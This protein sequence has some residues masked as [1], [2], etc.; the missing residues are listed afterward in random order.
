MAGPAGTLIGHIG[1][2]A[3][4]MILGFWW[5]WELVGPARA[6]VQGEP[7]ERTLFPTVLKILGVFV[8]VPIEMPNS[9]WYPMDWVMGW[10]HITMYL[11]FGGSALVDLAARRELLSARATHFGLAG[12]ALIGALLFYGHGIDPGVEGTAHAIVAM[13]FLSVTLFTILEVVAPSWG[14]EWFR[15]GSMIAL[16]AWMAI[17]GWMLF[18]SGWDLHDHVRVGHVWLRLAWT[19]MAVS[20]VTTLGSIR[21]NRAS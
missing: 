16:G 4:F 15:I 2:G 5:L 13:L 6:R 17:T 8:A 19:L 21:V 12:A 11:A 18:R 9:G 20:L 10:H 7:V 1:P 3:A 14:L